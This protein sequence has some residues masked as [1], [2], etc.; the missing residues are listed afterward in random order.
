VHKGI[1][2]YIFGIKVMIRMKSTKA[3]VQIS[4]NSNISSL[5]KIANI[6]R[7]LL[8]VDDREDNSFFYIVAKDSRREIDVLEYSFMS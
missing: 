8:K 5:K 1:S 2:E 7:N 6:G 4:R 3:F